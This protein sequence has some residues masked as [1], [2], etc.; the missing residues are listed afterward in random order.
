MSRASLFQQNP[1]RTLL[2]IWRVSLGIDFA[3]SSGDHVVFLQLFPLSLLPEMRQED[4]GKYSKQSQSIVS[5][6]TT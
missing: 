2:L 4:L 3:V 1:E 6:L 5:L